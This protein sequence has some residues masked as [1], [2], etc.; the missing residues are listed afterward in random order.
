M[1]AQARV[2]LPDTLFD[3]SVEVLKAEEEPEGNRAVLADRFTKREMMTS[4]A[5]T[6]NEKYQILKRELDQ[7]QKNYKKNYQEAY[8]NSYKRHQREIEPILKNY[9]IEVEEARKRF[10]SI[11]YKPEF[12]YNSEDPCQQPDHV[13]YPETPPFEFTFDPEIDPKN[14]EEKLSYESYTT[15]LDVLGYDFPR[16]QEGKT[17]QKALILTPQNII[18]NPLGVI[19]QFN[20]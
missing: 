9:S 5:K 2:S 6:A 15:L 13:P 20:F 17:I 16:E 12:P 11:D 1:L 7:L 14:L 18:A 19:K 3:D 10:C 8:E 4:K